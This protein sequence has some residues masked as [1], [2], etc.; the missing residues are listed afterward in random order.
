MLCSLFAL[1]LVGGLVSQ[2]RFHIVAL[3]TLGKLPTVS[4]REVGGLLLSP[5]H[6]RDPQETQGL[7]TSV[8]R[9]G[10]PPSCVRWRTP[11]GEFL[12]PESAED[13]LEL[14]IREQLIDRVYLNRWIDIGPGDVVLDV[15]SHLGTFARAALDRGAETVV[16]IEPNPSNL[17]CLRRTFASEIAAGRV[18]LVPAAAWREAGFLTFAGDGSTGRISYEGSLEVEARTLDSI[19]EELRLDRVDLIKMDIEGAELDALYGAEKIIAS[20]TPKMSIAV[21]HQPNHREDVPS[22]VREVTDAY[23]LRLT[24]D[25]AYFVPV[26]SPAG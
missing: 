10:S 23:R 7:V 20:N 22:W 24:S 12:G 13:S 1:V 11:L 26:S 6:D 14:Q 5:E 25:F 16:A 15:G 18:H 3:K 4:W 17:A 21:Y 19:V 9:T 2:G 8:D